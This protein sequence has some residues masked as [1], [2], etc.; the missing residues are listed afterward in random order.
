MEIRARYVLVGVFVI[1]VLAAGLGFVYWMENTTGLAKRTSYRIRF[2]QS[3]SGL[4]LGSGV[5]FNGIRVGEVTDLTLDKDDPNGV[6]V[7]VA[8]TSDTPVRSD[9]KVRLAFG[10]LTGVPEIALTGGSPDAPPPQAADGGIPTLE[11]GADA[12]VDWTVAASNAFSQVQSILSAN[13]DTLQNAISNI[14][15]FSQALAKNSDK[16]DGIVDGLARLAGAGGTK[17]S[18]NTILAAPTDFPR[19]AAPPTKQLVIARPTDVIALETQR[20]LVQT[21]S[22]VAPAFPDVQWSDSTPLLLQAKLVE[23]FEN[24]GFPKVSSDTAGLAADY[25][26]LIELRAFQ[27][28]SGDKPTAEI[29]FTAKL[30]DPSGAILATKRFQESAPL[31]AMQA[32]D[33]VAAF[34]KAFGAAAHALVDWTL[35]QMS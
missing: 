8:V 14:D 24:A 10:G 30:T 1:A 17:P 5:Q 4:L 33:A 7:T 6:L 22:T 21:G 2:E 25:T 3:V 27:I 23:A 9:T 15:T 31:A 29:D 28:V 13:S 26:L 19:L 11:A 32:H 20:I 16:L 18:G 34:D 12:G 35:P